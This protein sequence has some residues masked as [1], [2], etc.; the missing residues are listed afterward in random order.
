MSSKPAV[1][2]LPSILIPVSVLVAA[3]IV[4]QPFQ[5]DLSGK[6]VSPKRS[7]FQNI[8]TFKPA[9]YTLWSYENISTTSGVVQRLLTSYG[10]RVAVER[11]EG[12]T[13][14][15]C[16]VD[17]MK[18]KFLVGSSVDLLPILIMCL[19]QIIEVSW[20]YRSHYISRSKC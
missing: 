4:I 2:V 14:L 11:L 13:V 6:D 18:S 3:P 1:T 12:L 20:S 19:F 10:V 9:P 7:W 5:P 15:R 8:F 17:S 16:K